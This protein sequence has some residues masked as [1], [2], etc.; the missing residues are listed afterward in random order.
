M[1][2]HLSDFE[3][4]GRKITCGR[5]ARSIWEAAAGGA[6][7]NALSRRNGPKGSSGLVAMR[8]GATEVFSRLVLLTDLLSRGTEPAQAIQVLVQAPSRGS[9]DRCWKFICR[10]PLTVLGLHN[11]AAGT[12]E[13]RQL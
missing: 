12:L 7:L 3:T 6:V 4:N 11:M 5:K 13:A 9:L 1:H 8:I 10:G 2:T